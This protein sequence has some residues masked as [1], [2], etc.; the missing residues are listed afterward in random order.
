[1][2]G[3]VAIQR[4]LLILIYILWKKNETFRHDYHQGKIEGR[5]LTAALTN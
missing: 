3:A 2:K 5:Q 4:K 1:M